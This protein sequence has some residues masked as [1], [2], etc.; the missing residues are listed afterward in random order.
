MSVC[1]YSFMCSPV[2]R[3][4]PCD[5]LIPRPRQRAY[6]VKDQETEKPGMVEQRAVKP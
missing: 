5:E 1:V 2:C 6:C 3:Q 4:R